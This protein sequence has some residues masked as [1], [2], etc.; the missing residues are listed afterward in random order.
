M[1]AVSDEVMAAAMRVTVALSMIAFFAQENMN[2]PFLWVRAMKLTLLH[3]QDRLTSTIF[4]CHGIVNAFMGRYTAAHRFG[5]L[6][7]KLVSKTGAWDDEPVTETLICSFTSHWKLPIADQLPYNDKAFRVGLAT[8][9]TNFAVLA[10]ISKVETNF[11]TGAKQ[12]DAHEGVPPNLAV[13][14]ESARKV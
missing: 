4:A 9:N 11:A 10:D 1:P 13:R 3:G 5:M 8:G 6:S 12:E 14:I 7:R 2:Y